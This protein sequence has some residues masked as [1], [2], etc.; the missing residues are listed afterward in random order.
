MLH[1]ITLVKG[2]YVWFLSDDD[3][4]I[5]E[6]LEHL[7]TLLEVREGD[8]YLWNS[9]ILNSSGNQILIDKLP[10]LDQVVTKG[11]CNIAAQVGM[12]NNFAAISCAVFKVDK[13]SIDA[14]HSLIATGGPI[15]SH[16][17]NFLYSYRES[18]CFYI[19]RSLVNYKLNENGNG[20]YDRSWLEY[21]KNN[22]IP[23][24]Y[25]WTYGFLRQLAW[26]GSQSKQLSE[27][28]LYSW[29]R[30][31]NHI[32]HEVVI[33]PFV[34]ELRMQILL[35]I[36][37][38]LKHEA[39]S[40]RFSESELNWLRAF[41]LGSKEV[42]N[43]EIYWLD[44]I[45]NPNL[46][47]SKSKLLRMLNLEIHNLRT[48]KRGMLVFYRGQFANWDIYESMRGFSAVS[49]LSYT[50]LRIKLSGFNETRQQNFICVRN[51]SELLSMIRSNPII[52]SWS[53]SSPFLSE[54]RLEFQRIVQFVSTSY[55]FAPK[56][57]RDFIR[58]I[59]VRENTK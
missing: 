42:F 11:L 27:F 54:Y 43:T 19:D 17:S 2:E 29:Q 21:S 28:W 41:L 53:N 26:L 30:S 48:S 24:R 52:K 14:M 9:G 4:P 32:T 50:E 18:T 38:H 15:Y 8:F 37:D 47:T 36:K 6:S 20:E 58:Y 16:V 39:N 22:S 23:L 46:E 34:D 35:Y 10:H 49:D 3:V 33:N 13:F 5:F 56:F 7:L 1:L 45:L 51:Q 40:I 25:P 57:L 12:W 31:I 55:S 59:L 44:E